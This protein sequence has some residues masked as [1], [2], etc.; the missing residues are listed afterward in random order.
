ME[1]IVVK[2]LVIMKM[3]KLDEVGQMREDWIG[4]KFLW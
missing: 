3:L 2:E 4:L 1:G